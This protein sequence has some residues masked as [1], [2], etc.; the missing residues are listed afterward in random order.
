MD[1]YKLVR[2]LLSVYVAFSIVASFMISVEARILSSISSAEKDIKLGKRI[3]IHT[4]KVII[5]RLK[6]IIHLMRS[7]CDILIYFP[8]D[9]HIFYNF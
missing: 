6:L 3:G 4:I 1:Y 7:D 2:V 9:D 5:Y 8:Y